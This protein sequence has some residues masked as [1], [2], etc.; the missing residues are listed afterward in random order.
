M[1]PSRA[2]LLAALLCLWAPGRAVNVAPSLSVGGTTF[3][4]LGQPYTVRSTTV[5]AWA[6][7][8]PRNR[9]PCGT[10]GLGTLRVRA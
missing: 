5:V 10:L 1:A 9:T 8:Q 6:T 7:P 3:Y 4:C 2:L